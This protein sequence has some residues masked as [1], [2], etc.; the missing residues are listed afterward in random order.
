MISS[1]PAMRARYIADSIGTA[2]PARLLMMLY[3]RL[4]LDLTRTEEAFRAGRR[5]AA[6]ATM[7]NAQE[8]VF[9]LR[10]TLKHDG[11]DGAGKLD[12]IYGFLLTELMAAH[13][14]A[15]ADRIA[16]CRA[17]VEP[18]R[19]AWMLA[20]LAEAETPAPSATA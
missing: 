3:D 14:K 16:A 12:Q 9:E 1:N 20:A 8:I 6:S 13:L 2:S 11:W 4:I 7:E 19:D 5:D 17:L 18:L 15:D 10:V